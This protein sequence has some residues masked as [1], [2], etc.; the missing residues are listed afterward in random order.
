MFVNRRPR[1]HSDFCDDLHHP[2]DFA[3]EEN[4]SPPLHLLPGHRR[5]HL[6]HF[7]NGWPSHHHPTLRSRRKSS[8][9]LRTGHLRHRSQRQRSHLRQ[10][11]RL[12]EE[13][14]GRCVR[15]HQIQSPR[16]YHLS[17]HL[18]RVTSVL[19]WPL[20]ASAVHSHSQRYGTSHEKTRYLGD[21]YRIHHHFLCLQHQ[22]VVWIYVVLRICG[23]VWV[24]LCEIG[25]QHSRQLSFRQYPHFDQS[26]YHRHRALL[27]V[28]S[29]CT[30]LSHNVFCRDTTCVRW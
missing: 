29:L 12:R 23:M 3:A 4:H 14:S 2:S 6:S 11:Q 22:F 18:P 9:H 27:H 10:S 1:I 25:G 13:L 16:I 15:R 19:L 17:K 7:R 20:L 24:L 28:P 30:A 5:H 21:L 8:L 26:T